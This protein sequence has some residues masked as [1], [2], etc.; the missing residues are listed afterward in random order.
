MLCV[1]KVLMY[2]GESNENLTTFLPGN[3]VWIVPVQLCHFSAHWQ[4]DHTVLMT[5]SACL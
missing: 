4:D 2:V 5:C 1:I 3:L